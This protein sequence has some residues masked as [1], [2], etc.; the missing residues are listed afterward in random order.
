MIVMRKKYSLL[1]I[2]IVAVSACLILPDTTLAQ[3]ITVEVG[4]ICKDVVDRE[5]VDAD[6]TF[7]FTEEELCCYTKITGAEESTNITHVWYW[8]DTERARVEL[9]VRS[10]NWRT[11]SS[12]I[13]QEHETGAWRVEVLDSD[14]EVLKTLKFHITG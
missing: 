1:F 9:P 13:I 5:P 3:E 2:L 12:K 8:G 10:I 14:G 4:V 11:Y 7:S 6:T